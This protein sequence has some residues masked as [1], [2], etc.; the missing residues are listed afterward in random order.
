MKI[1][2]IGLFILITYLFILYKQIIRHA[3]K[4]LKSNSYSQILK[5][6]ISSAIT[7]NTLKIALIHESSK[8][9]LVAFQTIGSILMSTSDANQAQDRISCLFMEIKLWKEALPYFFNSSEKEHML[10][11]ND[12]LHIFLRKILDIEATRDLKPYILEDFVNDLINSLFLKQ[13]YPGTISQ[14]ESFAL[15]MLDSILI[16]ASQT[17]LDKKETPKSRAIEKN[18]NSSITQTLISDSVFATLLSLLHSMWDATRE[19]AYCCTCQLIKLAKQESLALPHYFISKDS[20]NALRARA[21]HLASSP[22]QREADTGSKMIAILCLVLTTHDEQVK[23][24]EDLS[25]FTATRLS[26]MANFLGVT[27][28]QDKDKNP[29]TLK[30]T[31]SDNELPLAHGL[32]QAFRH[33]I[34]DNKM[35]DNS[36]SF[37]IFTKLSNI[38]CQAIE[39]SLVVVADINVDTD[40]NIEQQDGA[41]IKQR[42]RLARSKKTGST[43]L[44]V[45]TGALGA[46]ATF[47]SCKPINEEESVQRLS[48]QRILVSVPGNFY[49]LSDTFIS[50]KV[51]KR[52]LS[53]RLDPGYL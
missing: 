20:Y 38:F 35:I 43:P 24:V 48:M 21:T 37:E 33:I 7:F 34:D 22:R 45:N 27:L 41:V 25:Q 9:R 44:N 16:F 52:V 11:L 18:W 19:R 51:A 10:V 12:S 49:S 46:N 36:E 42:W 13:A 29:D 15:K 14:K 31:K 30:T 3:N 6:K 5:E 32:I 39:V 17:K 23:Y 1:K 47:V 40:K 26:L 8:I 2:K 28:R 50:I 4:L 53:Y